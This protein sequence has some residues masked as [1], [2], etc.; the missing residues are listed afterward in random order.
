VLNKKNLIFIALILFSISSQGQSF[1]T[2]KDSLNHFSI[3][4][5]VGW[6][7]GPRKDYPSIKLMAYRTPASAT[8]TSKDN[9]NLNVVETPNSNL[10]EIYP[11]FFQ[12]IKN[13]ENFKLLDSGET[14]ING[15]KF[16]WLIETHRY[17]SDNIQMHNYDFVTY[18]NDKTYVITFTTFSNRFDIVKPTFLIIANSFTL[19]K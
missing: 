3:K 17:S 1:I 2:Y 15:R 14:T 8:D 16:R 19:T 18:Q 11:Q 5:P 4:I 7:Y 13:A 12:S 6:K 9:F 10:N